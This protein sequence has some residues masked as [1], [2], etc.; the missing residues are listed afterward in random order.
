VA[1]RSRRGS[2]RSGVGADV[3]ETNVVYADEG[4]AKS[5]ELKPKGVDDIEDKIAEVVFPSCPSSLASSPNIF[6]QIEKILQC[7]LT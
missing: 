4:T 3:V 2:G 5:V 6:L 7:R 1:S